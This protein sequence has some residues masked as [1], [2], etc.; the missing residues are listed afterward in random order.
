MSDKKCHIKEKPAW[1]KGDGAQVIAPTYYAP[2]Q[3]WYPLYISAAIGNLWEAA[4]NTDAKAIKHLET[5]IA[6][7][8]RDIHQR[9]L[10]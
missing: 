5:A 6:F 9:K 3:E 10:R 1:R 2:T 4:N 8:Q 7:I